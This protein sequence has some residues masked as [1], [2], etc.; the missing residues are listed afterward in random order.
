MLDGKTPSFQLPRGEVIH[1]VIVRLSDGSIVERRPSELVKRPTPPQ[2][3][4]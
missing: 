3:K 1:T 4:G 2:P